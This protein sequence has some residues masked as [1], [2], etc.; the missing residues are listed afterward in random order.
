M[1]S[2]KCGCD[3]SVYKPLCA[4]C[5]LIRVHSIIVNDWAAYIRGAYIR[6]AYQFRS[7]EGAGGRRL[8]L[9][10]E[11]QGDFAARMLLG[12]LPPKSRLG[13]RPDPAGGSNPQTP[14]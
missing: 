5:V 2:Q 1:V 14:S 6:G 4:Y 13:L 7:Q 11:P 12:V 8:G 3:C 10:P 9:R